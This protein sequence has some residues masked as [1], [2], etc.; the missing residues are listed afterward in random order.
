M[1]CIKFK[2]LYKDAK[3]F[4]Y[5]HEYDACMDMYAY[6]DAFIGPGMTTIV[7]TG[8]SVEIPP[9]YEGLVRGRSGLAAKGISVH[10]GTIDENYRGDVGI[11]VHNSTPFPTY[12]TKGERIAQFTIK[13]VIR[14]EL[15]ETDTLTD[16]E[17]GT[18]GY[19][20]SGI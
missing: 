14:I 19:G 2:K 3:P 10:L 9:G 18:N 20:S 12:I 16:T 13:P 8:I 17:R 11:I 4:T 1:T 6:T 5:A 15:I 7:P